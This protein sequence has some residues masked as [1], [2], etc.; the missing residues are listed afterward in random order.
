M[1]PNLPLDG[2]TTAPP[3]PLVPAVWGDTHSSWEL[4]L[5]SLGVPAMGTESCSFEILGCKASGR[6]CTLFQI[7]WQVLSKLS[8]GVSWWIQMYLGNGPRA[9]GRLAT[10][11]VED[12]GSP[13]PLAILLLSFR[14]P[15]CPPRARRHG[16]HPPPPFIH[17]KGR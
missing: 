14:K 6:P 10:R 7:S 3:S 2:Q 9:E 4:S 16:D 15:L 11:A 5:L 17:Q 1:G 8:W 12:K 13:F